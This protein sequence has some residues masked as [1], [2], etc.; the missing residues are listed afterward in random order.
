MS[1]TTTTQ[2]KT[3]MDPATIAVAVS[4]LITLGEHIAE[5][6][7]KYNDPNLIPPTVA[8]VKAHLENFKAQK[9]LP[10]TVDQQVVSSVMGGIVT[11]LQ[12][13]SS[14]KK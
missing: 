5:L 14:I 9:P 3:E 1:E 6:V 8:E 7:A 2:E 4:T 10:E 11:W 13:L 12:G